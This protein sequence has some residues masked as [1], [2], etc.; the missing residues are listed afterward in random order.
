MARKPKHEER[1]N[2]ERWL[3]SYADFITLLFAFFVVMYSIS[4]INEGKYRVL[5][6]ALVAAFRNAP[7]SLQPIQV[8][9]F[10]RSPVNAN[11]SV[12]KNPN[13][14][15]LPN[16]PVLRTRYDPV[17]M[18]TPEEAER[19]QQA[20]KRMTEEIEQAMAPLIDRELIRVRRSTGWV[21]V[22]I[23]TS[24]LFPSGSARLSAEAIPILERLA[25]ILRPFP[26]PIH[27]EGFTDNVPINTPAFPSNWELSA[28]R[29]AS[30][31]HLF[32]KAN[33]DP[34]RMAAIGFGEYRPVADN[35]TEEG[36]SKNRRVV[37]VVL[38]EL[39]DQ[40]L[41]EL[42]Q[43]VNDAIAPEPTG[44]ENV[45]EPVPSESAP[46]PAAGSA[47]GGLTG[48]TAGVGE[49]ANGIDKTPIQAIEPPIRLPTPPLPPQRREQ[50]P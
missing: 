44:H 8:G 35:S 14:V 32:T 43:S 41:L 10:V 5:S 31:V 11:T 1:E 39:Q 27:V 37:I 28:A 16:F 47:N 4:S 15:D 26:N 24:I 29:A 25:E 36:R 42:R 38:A 6:D 30:V 7:Q 34:Q 50:M 45:P 23:N 48:E 46:Q 40:Q 3:I 21:E 13:V 18:L 9:E 12:I 49:P 22:E 2:H 19:A 20:M 33:I 17:R